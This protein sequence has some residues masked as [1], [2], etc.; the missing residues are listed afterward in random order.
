MSSPA[1]TN[2]RAKLLYIDD[3]VGSREA[4]S[5]TLVQRDF[6]V[7]C[8]DSGAH[9]LQ[10]LERFDCDVLVTDLRMPGM[11]GVELCQRVHT[12]WPQLPVVLVTAFGSLETAVAA[13]RAGAYDFITK[14]I[15]VPELLLTLTRALEH[16]RLKEENQQL[17]EAAAEQRLPST[18]I[19]QSPAMQAIYA[20]VNRVAATDA[21]VLITGESGTGKELVAQ[22]VHQ[23]SARA[24]APLVAFNC[25][26]LPESMIDSELF[27]HA[28]GAFTDA[29]ALHKGLFV[30][31]HGGTLF[32]DEIGEM[33]LGMQVKLLR[34]LQER[35]V[36]PVGGEREIGFDA[37]L[38]AATSRDLQTDVAEGRFREDLFYRLN[39]I[40][41]H[42]PPLRARG[43]DILAIADYYIQRFALRFDKPVTGLSAPAAD[44][45]LAY[46]WPGNVREL[47]NCLERAVVLAQSEWIML[48][49]LPEHI[50]AFER[51]HFLVPLESPLELLPMVEVERRYILQVLT[52]LH[53]SKS[54]AALALGFDR[55]TLYRKLKA[56]GLD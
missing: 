8:A 20:V 42:M 13:I 10:V 54:Q 25:A 34:A 32:L 15:Q 17:R 38:V 21:T 41:I 28:R 55:R 26:A 44:K 30:Q 5:A 36:R 1:K 19:G 22:A 27:G 7:V 35:V 3:D 6:E 23:R 40:P 4:V 48:D 24:A 52:A 47:Q 16:R 45:L 37:R 9:A 56:Y 31:A 11:S 50:C 29:K 53:G 12:S 14:P 33:P 46:S 39:V 49:D 18:M 2:T 43:H 51:T